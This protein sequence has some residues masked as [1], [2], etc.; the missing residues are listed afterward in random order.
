MFDANRFH[1]EASV[2]T[3]LEKSNYILSKVG[4]HISSMCIIS[5][6]LNY[7][8]RHLSLIFVQPKLFDGHRTAQEELVDRIASVTIAV[9][10]ENMPI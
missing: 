4:S 9:H 7:V 1:I 2:K 10:Y 5:S 8:N 6:S 3:V